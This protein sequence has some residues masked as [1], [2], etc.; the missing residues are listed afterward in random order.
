MYQKLGER[1][2]LVYAGTL[3]LILTV[4]IISGFVQFKSS[5]TFNNLTVHRINVVEPDGTLR[6]VISDQAN[7]PGAY[8]KNKEYPFKRAT[9]GMIFY[10]NE[11]T[12]DG[13]L[14]FGSKK[15]NGKIKSWGHLSFDKYM[16]DQVFT[17]DADQTGSKGSVSLKFLDEPDYPITKDL[18]LL[19][20]LHGLSRSQQ[21]LAISKFQSKN[22][23]SHPRLLLARLPNGSV[24]MGLND[25]MGRPRIIL[26]V[27]VNGT[28]SI[29]MLD[30]DGNVISKQKP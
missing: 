3:T 30:A 22:G 19:N 1:F 25:T 29:Q 16:Q 11:G 17:I 7:F 5:E 10:D 23:T 21:K 28:P 13:G 2:L 6:M 18:K 12:E 9:A 26:K 24:E 15:Q 4:G 14:I 20:Q 8:V 27:G